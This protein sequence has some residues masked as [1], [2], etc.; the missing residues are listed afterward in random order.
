MARSHC[1]TQIR[2]RIPYTAI[3]ERVPSVDLCNVNIQHITIVAKGKTLRIRVRQCERAIKQIDAA[4]INVPVTTQYSENASLVFNIF[5]VEIGKSDSVVN[6]ELA[7]VVSGTVVVV[8]VV[9]VV[10][11][12][13]DEGVI[14][15]D[16]MVVTVVV[17][18][19]VVV[20][21]CVVV[22]R[23]DTVSVGI[24]VVVFRFKN[25][26]IG[27]ELSIDV[28]GSIVVVSLIMFE[29]I[30]LETPMGEVSCIGVIT[31]DTSVVKL[32]SVELLV[33]GVSVRVAGKILTLSVNTVTQQS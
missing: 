19:S 4:L 24:S 10:V 3:E 16:G 21:V 6:D 11:V 28:V 17:I 30:E 5:S 31:G 27:V 8:V 25:L 14:A 15:V 29:I 18:C 1:R 23:S 20:V 26:N 13:A 33:N 32:L 9:A 2:T 22:V 12:I 7:F